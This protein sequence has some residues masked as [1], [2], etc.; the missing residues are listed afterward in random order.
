MSNK[1]SMRDEER[2]VN[3]ISVVLQDIN[4]GKSPEDAVVD[5]AVSRKLTPTQTARVCE[6]CNKMSAIQRLSSPD[7]GCKKATF[8]LADPKKVS[9]RLKDM[10]KAEH[11][12]IKLRKTASDDLPKA[13]VPM[14]VTKSLG[15]THL[16]RAKV[17]ARD[18]TLKVASIPQELQ[19]LTEMY[20]HKVASSKIAHARFED[21]FADLITSLEKAPLKDASDLANYLANGDSGQQEALRTIFD[22]VPH[23][24]EYRIKL[25]SAWEPSGS[26]LEGKADA[27]ILAAKKAAEADLDAELAKKEALD[28]LNAGLNTI[29]MLKDTPLAE[30]DPLLPTDNP[31]SVDTT[32]RLNELAMKDSFANMY[33]DDDFLKQY[34]PEVVLDAYNKVLQMIPGLHQR[35]NADALVTS[36]VKKL[37]TAGN[38]IDPLEI[39]GLTTMAKNLAQAQQA[40]DERKWN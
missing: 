40:S 6:A 18:I 17:Y 29:S 14:T 30:K 21:A 11:A 9:K 38:Q 24:Q 32:N 4:K 35:Q 28:L 23:Y 12:P 8:P 27:F 34:E 5:A 19:Y 16:D 26:P 7:V 39:E 3:T 36:M 22:Y 20:D 2:M 37:I 15:I 25:A 31:F 10:D 13:D 1:M 33:L